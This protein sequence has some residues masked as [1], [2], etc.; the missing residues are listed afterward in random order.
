MT[1][2]LPLGPRPAH[3]PGSSVNVIAN[4]SFESGVYID[5]HG[6]SVPVNWGFE[7]CEGEANATVGI[8]AGLWTDGF[9][10]AKVSTGPVTPTGCI[11]GDNYTGR[12]VG[13]TQFRQFLPAQGYNFTQLTDSPAGFSFW[14]QLQP[15][16]NNGMASFE[17]RIF[18][19]EDLAEL[20][21][22]FNPDP[23]LGY[24]NNTS[25]HSLLFYGY[26]PGQWYHFSRNM[27][28]DWMTPMGLGNMPLALNHNFTLV[29]FEG[30]AINSGTTVKSETFWLDDVR[31]Y[32]GTGQ[33][34]ADT[35]WANFNLT[36]TKGNIV[37]PRV[38]WDLLNSTGQPVNYTLGDRTL[39]DGPYTLEAYYPSL[40][41]P[42]KIYK[43]NIHLDTWPNITLAMF[44]QNSVPNGYLALNNPVNSLQITQQDSKALTFKVQATSG[45]TYS[46][47]TDVPVKPTLIQLNGYDLVQ[48]FDWRYYPSLAIIT[49]TAS[50]NGDT[51]SLYFEQTQRLPTI[52][53]VDAT[54]FSV[55]NK[56]TFRILDPAGNPVQYSYGRV[57]PVSNYLLEAYYDGFQVYK[58][59]LSFTSTGPTQI[60]MSPL[61]TNKTNYLAINSTVTVIVSEN[62]D[63]RISFTMNGPG[64]YL[65]V[66]NVPVKPLFIERNGVR[67]ADWVYNGTSRTVAIETDQ[68]GTFNVVLRTSSSVS[69]IL[70]RGMGLAAAAAISILALFLRKKKAS[71]LLNDKAKGKSAKPDT[72]I[73][74]KKTKPDHTA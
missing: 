33:P 56:V 58:A 1:S 45:L 37:N 36:D 25:T 64:P 23:S 61:N 39:T 30:L 41:Q 49:F 11:P 31:A 24:V 72:L 57:V 26:Q 55:D 54:G 8:D 67:T 4:S 22:I 51:F 10:S 6:Y 2:L 66:V 29:Q 27:W 34:P 53:F 16:N 12:S 38:K 17:V 74:D 42:F 35:H 48:D 50:T 21:Y 28:A 7:T 15:Y 3:A 13:F 73:R 44:P 65:I 40:A 20:D 69:T 47:I 62:S 70:L 60:Q 43:A 46:L 5:P 32:V 14:F 71:K 68:A 19:A 9:N 52:Q 59:P 63:S 18:G